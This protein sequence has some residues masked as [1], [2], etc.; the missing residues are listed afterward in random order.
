MRPMKNPEADPAPV[1]LP[2]TNNPAGD[3][4]PEQG[5]PGDHPAGDPQP[6]LE[7][8]LVPYQYV[9]VGG[10]LAQDLARRA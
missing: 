10:D 4:K 9:G 1:H 7:I 2:A 5:A 8:L 3:P 6:L